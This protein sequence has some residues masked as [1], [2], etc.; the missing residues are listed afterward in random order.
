MLRDTLRHIAE[1]FLSARLQPIGGHPLGIYLRDTA[2]QSVLDA[3][4]RDGFIVKGSPGQPPNW[5]DVPWIGV[6]NPEVTTSALRG[7][8]VVYLFAADMTRVYLCLGQGVTTVYEEFKRGG[9]D[10]LRRRAQLICARVPEYKA[11]FKS[12]QVDPRGL[13]SIRLNPA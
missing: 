6:F 13:L 9:R 2:A 3:L 1:N 5:A 11:R 8:Y 7:Y 12:G 4:G 10:E